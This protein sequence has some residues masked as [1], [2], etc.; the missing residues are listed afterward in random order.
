M[1]ELDE[2]EKPSAPSLT[3]AASCETIDELRAEIGLPRWRDEHELDNA[4]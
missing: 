4:A 2:R 3:N 1:A